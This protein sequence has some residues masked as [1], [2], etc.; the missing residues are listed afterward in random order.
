MSRIPRSS[1]GSS[2]PCWP[3]SGVE[4]DIGSDELFAAWRTFFERLADTAPVVL[5]FEDLQHADPGL[6]DFIDHVMEWS[7]GVPITL[8]ALARPGAPRPAIGL[9]GRACAAFTSIHLEPL[10]PADMERLLAGLVP[11]LPAQGHVRP[12]WRGRTASPCTRSRPC[13]CCSPRDASCSR[14]GCASPR[15]PW[16]RSRS[17]RP[18]RPSSPRASTAWTPPTG[19]W[20]PMPRSWARASAPRP[21]PRSRGPT[22][23]SSRPGSGASSG[24][25]CSPST[26]TPAR[27]GAASTPSSRPWSA[28][29]RT[30]RS[31][32]ATGKQRHLAAAR[33]LESL[34]S[35]E[36]AGALADHVPGGV[37]EH[38]A[39][40]RG[41]CPRRP[42]PDNA[43]GR[44]HPGHR[45][46]LPRPGPR[47][48]RAGPRDHDRSRR[49]GSAPRGRACRRERGPRHRGHAAPRRGRGPGAT[50]GR[51]PGGDRPGH[52]R[53]AD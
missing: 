12:S 40:S 38:P 1:A 20:S 19:P 23:P 4:T 50:A 53:M 49:P 5:V 22:R 39:R 31:R 8:I 25:S 24:G 44:R 21:S 9:G 13:G 52:R 43:A 27:P 47:L 30:T 33:Y 6:L 18:S 7:R 36:L 45:P 41:R 17:R 2:P 34:G 42:G 35:D 51:G 46:G 29:S 26:S 28:R 48:P 15:G 14:T 11:G 3:C 10:P 16:T 37:P 32:G